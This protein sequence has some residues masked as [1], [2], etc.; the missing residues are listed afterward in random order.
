MRICL[1]KRQYQ[2]LRN[3]Q[4]EQ[5]QS[6]AMI[7]TYLVRK[8]KKEKRG[9]ILTSIQ[10]DSWPRR[11]RAKMWFKNRITLSTYFTYCVCYHWMGNYL[12]GFQTL[13]L[14]KHS[15]MLALRH[16]QMQLHLP[17]KWSTKWE[18][19]VWKSRR[20]SMIVAQDTTCTCYHMFTSFA[21]FSYRSR[22]WHKITKLLKYKLNTF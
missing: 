5:S 7:T 15:I 10:L 12:D 21:P 9:E 18:K 1:R 3:N 2:H 11:Y 22:C 4:T 8:R 13:L 6:I 17:I 19:C 16:S 20:Y 14:N